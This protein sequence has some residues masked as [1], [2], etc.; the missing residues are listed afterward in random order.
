MQLVAQAAFA[1]V[2]SRVGEGSQN[3]HVACSTW[4]L[5]LAVRLE[6]D[7]DSQPRQ[8]TSNPDACRPSTSQL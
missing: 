1:A 8:A 6:Q 4:R 2:E 7:D 5:E 3:H